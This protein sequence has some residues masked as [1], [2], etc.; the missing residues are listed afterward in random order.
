MLCAID[1][2]SKDL[3]YSDPTD[4]HNYKAFASEHKKHLPEFTCN[5]IEEVP[6]QWGNEK[7]L[8]NKGAKLRIRK[9]HLLLQAFY[10]LSKEFLSETLDPSPV[11]LL[12]WAN[13]LAHIAPQ[14]FY[15]LIPLSWSEQ[16]QE[17][18]RLSATRG[19]RGWLSNKGGTR[20][21]SCFA[22]AACS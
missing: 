1:M 9:D 10:F 22:V 5:W 12:A 2:I 8:L 11:F 7:L 4:D 16:L 15:K 3:E 21:S 6:R 19:C 17:P 13:N 20:V 18:Y 14:K